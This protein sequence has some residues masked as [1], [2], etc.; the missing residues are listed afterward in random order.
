[1]PWEDLD[2]ELAELFGAQAER[3]EAF[4]EGFHTFRHVS[5]RERRGPL[6][7]AQHE[8]KKNASRREARHAVALA[9]FMSGV[10]PTSCTAPRCHNLLPVRANRGGIV[11]T[12]CSR[13][14]KQRKKIALQRG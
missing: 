11:R 13:Y 4:G 1:M 5:D 9:E 10:R 6:A 14:C 3:A 2:S 7:Y 8:A 12:T